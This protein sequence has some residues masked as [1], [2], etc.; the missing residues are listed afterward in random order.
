MITDV[1]DRPIADQRT[2]HDALEPMLAPEIDASA[3]SLAAR[4][5]TLSPEEFAAWLSGT[6]EVVARGSSAGD[7]PVLV[8]AAVEAS[9][10]TLAAVACL[11]AL[12]AVGAFLLAS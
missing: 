6:D 5:R 12:L 10:R 2:G 9:A 11:L 7:H 4:A 3:P 8:A 1:R